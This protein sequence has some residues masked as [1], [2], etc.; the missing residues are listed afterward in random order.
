MEHVAEL[1]GIQWFSDEYGID[2]VSIKRVQRGV[3]HVYRLDA[4]SVGYFLRVSPSCGRT[5]EE[6][7]VELQALLQFRSAPHTRL[8]RP[9]RSA[10]NELV[11]RLPED[12]SGR[13]FA[14][15][16]EARGSVPGQSPAELFALGS[17]IARLHAGLNAEKPSF[18]P[19]LLSPR[20]YGRA[21]ELLSVLKFDLGSLRELVLEMGDFV[22]SRH[23]KAAG[24]LTWGLCHGDLWFKNV[25]VS[26]PVATFFDFERCGFGPLAYDIATIADKLDKTNLTECVLLL[27]EIVRGYRQIGPLNVADLEAVPYLAVAYQLKGIEWLAEYDQLSA[28]LW[29]D[30][31]EKCPRLF[32]FWRQASV[33]DAI[34]SLDR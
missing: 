33:M 1:P 25:H 34:A 9:L 20:L 17:H 8:A 11:C 32:Q 21:G 2:I 31:A 6:I 29:L 19:L 26:G 7:E 13:P 23:E 14:L 24:E 3:N 22:R 4:A 15:F 28:E 5:I 16:E 27:G 18:H 10:N 12:Y 30:A